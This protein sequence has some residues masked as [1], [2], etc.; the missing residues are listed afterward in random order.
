MYILPG[1]SVRHQ[2]MSETYTFTGALIA[3]YNFPSNGRLSPEF[4][5]Y[6]SWHVWQEHIPDIAKKRHSH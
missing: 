2:G 3:E 6:H 4:I 5:Y 1:L